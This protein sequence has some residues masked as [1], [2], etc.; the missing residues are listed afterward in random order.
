MM[1]SNISPLTV[2][3]T[4]VLAQRLL[5]MADDELILAHRDSEWTGH[6]PILE[7]DIAIANIAQDEL[8]L[9]ST[10]YGMGETLTGQTPDQLACFRE[11]A[12]FLSV[13]LVSLPKGDWAFTMLRQYLFDAYEQVL[14]ETAVSKPNTYQ[15]LADALAKFRGEE[16]YHLRHT[17]MWVERLGLGT[18]ESR[19]RMQ[20]ALDELWPLCGQLFVPLPD[21]HLLVAAGLVPDVAA[22]VE[23]WRGIV[24]PHLVA[25]GLTLPQKPLTEQTE[26]LTRLLADMQQVSRFDPEAE[27]LADD[28]KDNPVNRNG[29][30]AIA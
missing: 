16:M 2:A 25:S 18:D 19:R 1:S 29:R 5:A 17:H 15:P 7:E 23:S 28:G 6:G 9:A 8:G 20:T 26:H 13:Q 27:F 22:L 10:F 11:A 30:L 3:Q 12:K 4:A 24:E 14:I 21:E